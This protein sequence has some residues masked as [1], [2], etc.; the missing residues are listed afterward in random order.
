MA[1]VTDAGYSDSSRTADV[2]VSAE[3]EEKEEEESAGGASSLRAGDGGVIHPHPL[4]AAAPL[5]A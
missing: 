5:R 3:E 4:F 2:A 1:M